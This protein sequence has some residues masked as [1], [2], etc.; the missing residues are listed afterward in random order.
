MSSLPD[1]SVDPPYK[2]ILN[3]QDHLTKFCHLKP[4]THKEGAAVARELFHIFSSFGAPLILQ[5]DNG[6]EFRNQ[7]VS[8]LKLLWP[9]LKILHGRSRRPQTQGSVERCNG[10]FQNILGSWMR[11]NKTSKWSIGLPIV[12]YIKNRK[13]NKGIG[14]SPYNA[15]F[16]REAYNGLEILNLPSGDKVDTLTDLYNKLSGNFYDVFFIYM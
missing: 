16:G 15:L 5:S 8:G 4:L 2:Y 9:D 12:Q 3:C 14:T 13:Y 11:E 6:P 10:D 7:V 1:H